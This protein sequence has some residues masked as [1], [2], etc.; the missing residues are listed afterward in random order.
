[1]HVA[2]ARSTRQRLRLERHRPEVVV[3][4]TPTE[5]R[6]ESL[7]Q[8]WILRR[9]ARRVLALMPVVVKA[10]CRTN[11]GVI[12]GV[13][14]IVIAQSNHRCDTNRDGVGTK[15]QGLRDVGTIAN[16]TRHDQLH[17]AMHAHLLQRLDGL[18]DT[19]QGRQA[20]VLDKDVL[21][22]GR[23]ALHAIEHDHI[24]T[25][26]DGQLRVVI[27][28]AGTD[29]DVDRLLP[30][31]NLADLLDLDLEIVRPRP[32]GMTTGAALV[33]ALRQIAHL[34]NTIRDLLTQQHAA[35]ARLSALA[36]DDLDRV[37]TTQIVGVHSV[38]RWQHLVDEDLGMPA[39]LLRHAAVTGRRRRTRHRGATSERLLGLPRQRTE[40]HAGNRDR[41]LQLDRLLGKARA[42]RDARVAALAIALEGI[43]RHARSEEQQVIEVR[44]LALGTEATDVVD[45]LA[46]CSSNLLDRVAIEDVRLAQT[47]LPIH[48]VAGLSVVIA[49]VSPSGLV[50]AGMVDVEV[51]ETACGAVALELIDLGV[52]TGCS[53]Q[54]SEL[55]AMKLLEFLLD[56]VR[57]EPFD[58]ATHVDVRLVDRVTERI[59]SIATDHKRAGLS[60]KRT[61]VTD[62]ALDDDLD[63][64]HRDAAACRS[65]AL[66]DYETATTRRRA[67]LRGVAGDVDRAAHDVLAAANTH[68]AV[69]AH[70]RVLVH[71]RRVVA[72]VSLDLDLEGRVDTNRDSV[73]AIWVD[74]APAQR[75][76]SGTVVQPLV[77]FAERR[78]CEVDNLN[79]RRSC[80]R[81]ASFS[82]E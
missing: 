51:V 63:T 3:E 81:T 4:A 69:D 29:L 62:A 2:L 27:R 1:M 31:G 32:V 37:G 80:H 7:R 36:N 28:A 16:T 50:L 41:D 9:N 78:R 66:D 30:V 17:L 10:G 47:R 77:E 48:A 82:H 42:E 43:A 53:Q 75:T 65:I 19:G 49:H 38:P 6:V 34:G 70:M 23:A 64:L 11:L 60:H 13:G 35:A 46:G 68:V 12:I 5:L 33:D 55:L 57:A 54:T 40:T 58:R 76:P 8:F 18:A 25:G 39:L 24:G 74:D 22:G 72:G 21:R 73:C 61:H 26:L 20:D 79:V 71:A 56:A 52:G 44:Q 45:A 67:G 14:R 59:A 15:C